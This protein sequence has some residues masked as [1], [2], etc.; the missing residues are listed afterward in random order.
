VFVVKRISPGTETTPTPQAWGKSST[1]AEVSLSPSS[2]AGLDLP[3]PLL[4]RQ[5][6]NAREPSKRDAL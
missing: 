5:G 1:E 4:V 6:F 2:K 3:S